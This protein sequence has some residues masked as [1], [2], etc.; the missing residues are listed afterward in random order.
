MSRVERFWADQ[1][2]TVIINTL[3]ANSTLRNS[4]ISKFN[5]LVE[6]TTSKKSNQVKMDCYRTLFDIEPRKKLTGF[7]EI[8]NLD[9]KFRDRFLKYSE[10][11][12]DCAEYFTPMILSHSTADYKG[13]LITFLQG[14]EK[15]LL[16]L[17]G[18]M[19]SELVAWAL[20]EGGVDFSTVI[21]VWINNEGKILNAGDI[22]YAIDFC[23]N[24]NITP[25][26]KT[27]NLE[28]L[29][30]SDEF[31]EFSKEL[32]FNSPQLTTHAYMVKIMKDVFPNH[33][34]LF[35]GEV[36]FEYLEWQNK[37]WNVSYLVKLSNLALVSRTLSYVA[38][39][40]DLIDNPGKLVGQSRAIDKGT[41]AS[42]P[43]PW[44]G[45]W[46]D[47]ELGGTSA[48]PTYSLTAFQAW[49]NNY[50]KPLPPGVYPPNYT[51]NIVSA[52]PPIGYPI[53]PSG[54]GSVQYGPGY[55]PST[56][57]QRNGITPLNEMFTLGIK[58]P[59]PGQSGGATVKFDV[60]LTIAGG[61]GPG[62]VPV[63]PISQSGSYTISVSLNVYIV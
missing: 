17:S 53:I 52:V 44:V 42:D 31:M 12:W 62:G 7:E 11:E 21:F 20:I 61:D 1:G 34:H 63:G 4:Y 48:S 59:S 18:G 8:D 60:S 2:V 22:K 25:V 14:V 49:N 23:K 57:I 43:I 51:M 37:I 24:R 58:Y 19:D 16:Y 32:R 29:W 50:L 30:T 45:Y 9:R 26:L 40:Q 35:G 27:V 10:L 3:G 6:A 54:W 41:L 38:S 55:S 13:E 39:Q 15:P 5:H 56:V 33:T 28:K 46:Y 36:R 47:F